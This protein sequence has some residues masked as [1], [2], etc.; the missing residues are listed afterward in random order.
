[1]PTVEQ[2]T[3]LD[4]DAPSLSERDVVA[5]T[6]AVQRRIGHDLHDGLGQLLA[7]A[8]M[9]A[10]SLS[11]RAPAALRD[12]FER[13]VHT[14]ND[15]TGRVQSIARGLAPLRL[16]GISASEILRDAC[17]AVQADARVEIAFD[18]DPSAEHQGEAAN[19]QMSL[20]A[21]EAVRNALRH[22]HATRITVRL[23]RD[24]ERIVLSIHDNGAGFGVP[25]SRPGL[26]L[27]S[28]EYRA[29]ALGGSLEV[30][31]VEPGGTLVRGA[32]PSPL[33]P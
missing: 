5:V 10:K 33:T 1:M 23:D 15:A 19:V 17:A 13:L 25:R 31:A 4:E 32:W 24:G 6:D 14:L 7:G 18:I 27:E 30:K 29:R 20:I 28:M 8:A 2:G 3:T 12:D 11:Q 16:S 21:Q 9:I 22:G 26:G